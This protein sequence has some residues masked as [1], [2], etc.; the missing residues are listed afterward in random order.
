MLSSIYWINY[1]INDCLIFKIS[2]F[3]L[4]LVTV[5]INKE[6]VL[7][8]IGLTISLTE[9][10]EQDDNVLKQ[11]QFIYNA[12]AIMLLKLLKIS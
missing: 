9:L 2:F 3:L 11:H 4:N 6:Y 5:V 1:A 7:T 12:M 10:M 8:K